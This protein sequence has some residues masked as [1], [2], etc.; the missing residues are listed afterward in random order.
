[1]LTELKPR[2]LAEIASSDGET[3]DDE[4]VR[5]VCNSESI[6]AYTI[7]EQQK[8]NALFLHVQSR[9]ESASIE[10]DGY[11][12]LRFGDSLPFTTPPPMLKVWA[13]A[14]TRYKLH[15]HLRILD[16]SS[17]SGQHPVHANYEQTVKQMTALSEGKFTLGA[18]DKSASQHAVMFGSEAKRFGRDSRSGGPL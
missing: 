16:R 17:E 10:V 18:S 3:L 8:A 7:E 14:I 15:Q 4:L 5:R 1:M 6:G 11:L 2:E 13:L 9:C 12:A